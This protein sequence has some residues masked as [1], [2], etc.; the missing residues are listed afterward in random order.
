MK[1]NASKYSVSKNQRPFAG[2]SKCVLCLIVLIVALFPVMAHAADGCDSLSDNAQWQKGIQTLV[3]MM[4]ADQMQDA[5]RQAKALSEICSNSP[6][7]NYLQGKISEALDEKSDALYYYQKASENT[8][9]FAVDPDTAKKIWYA[10]YENEHPE[11]T[12]GAV[13][14]T[15]ER[16]SSLEAE[17]A[18]LRALAPYKDKHLDNVKA[19]M[20][21]GVGLGA[22]G[23]VLAG[24]GAGIIATNEPC[25]IVAHDDGRNPYTFKDKPVYSVGWALVGVGAGLTVTGAILAGIYGFKYTH[26]EIN[27]ESEVSLMLSPT[28]VSLGLTF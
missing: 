5:K 27:D 16:M 28:S 19:L 11:R 21:T 3:E 24:V 2:V 20:W 6:T 23:L 4:K 13:A 22:G 17:N 18:Q 26:F 12:K 10:R 1:T 14:S 7:L 9:T 8:Y 25:E 15:S